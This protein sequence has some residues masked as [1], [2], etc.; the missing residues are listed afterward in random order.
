M[1]IVKIPRWRLLTIVSASLL[2]GLIIGSLQAAKPEKP[3]QNLSE[4]CQAE[5]CDASQCER[6]VGQW[7]VD[8]AGYHGHWIH[9][10]IDNR[11]LQNA[12]NTC[13]HEVAHEEW[14]SYCMK[15]MTA[16]VDLTGSNPSEIFAEFCESNIT[17]CIEIAGGMK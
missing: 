12:L 16:C 1:T 7:T 5:K 10:N 17:K 13:A 2:L 14:D 4:I 3:M 6:V 9:V 11:T 15:N 8:K